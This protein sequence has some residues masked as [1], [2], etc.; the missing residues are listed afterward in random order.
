MDTRDIAVSHIIDAGTLAPGA[1]QSLLAHFDSITNQIWRKPA[2]V[3]QRLEAWVFAPDAGLLLGHSPGG[4][5]VAFS[6]YR[7]LILDAVLIVHRETTNVI[8]AV[9]GRGV[10]AAFTRRLRLDLAP[11]GG[12]LHLALR[13]RNPIIYMANYR[14]CEAMV[15]DLFRQGL[16]DPSL[17]DLAHRAAERL[18]PHLDLHRPSMVMPDAYVGTSYYEV[19]RH[20]DEAINTRFFATPG[21]AQPTSALFVLGRLKP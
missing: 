10:W 15:P 11:S 8:P 12:R 16:S 9:Q 1:R 5:L 19:P 18:Y 6:V 17:E 2:D 4:E 21:L 7:R 3:F 14:V 13:T 20:R